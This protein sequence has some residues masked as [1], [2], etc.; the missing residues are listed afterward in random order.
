METT[1][2]NIAAMKANPGAFF[3]SP[4]EILVDGRLSAAQ[5][6]ALLDA[7]ERDGSGPKGP[8]GVS[9]TELARVRRRLDTRA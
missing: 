3:A 7:W 4:A 2:P 6:R 5:K 9:P 1:Q 8:G